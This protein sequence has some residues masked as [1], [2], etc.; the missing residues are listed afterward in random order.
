M[1]ADSKLDWLNIGL[2]L[3]CWALAC[4]F[5]V[6]LL[7]ASYAILGPAHYLTEISWLHDRDYYA[8][9]LAGLA[10]AVLGCL[11]MTR[12]WPIGV[13]CLWAAF[14]LAAAAAFGSKSGRAAAPLAVAAAALGFSLGPKLGYFWTTIL[15]TA[16]H[17]YLF[18]A[19]FVAAGALKRRSATGFLSV[20]VLAACGASFFFYH[21]FAAYPLADGL[22]LKMSYFMGVDAVI[23]ARLGWTGYERAIGVMGFLSFAYTY[24]YLNWFSKAEVIKWHQT[25]RARWAVMAAAY[26]VLL[27]AYAW[28]FDAGFTASSMLSMAHVALEFP[29]DFRTAADLLLKDSP[30]G[31]GAGSSAV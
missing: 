28:S 10:L 24:H 18:T 20:L 13:P 14:A 8:G 22:R 23:M 3:G 2:M 29:L 27:G 6:E 4:R 25:P 17:V 11:V 1:S 31:V 5:P 15:P 7:L 21:P 12:R 26:A 16:V 9:K 19:L 30:S